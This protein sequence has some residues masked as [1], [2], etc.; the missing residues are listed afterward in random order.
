ME[1]SP[2]YKNVSGPFPAVYGSTGVKP[3]GGGSMRGEA[4]ASEVAI[5]VTTRFAPILCSTKARAASLDE[6]EWKC[7]FF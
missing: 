5:G 1:V 7:F 6:I 3:D 2:W 4:S